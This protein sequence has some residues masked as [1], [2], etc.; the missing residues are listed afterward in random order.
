M[1]MRTGESP[2]VPPERRGRARR[3]HF[4]T[5]AN[6]FGIESGSQLRALHVLRALE[7]LTSVSLLLADTSERPPEDIA[8]ARAA[9]PD[10]RILMVDEPR[11]RSAFRYLRRNLTLDTH[12][13]YRVVCQDAPAVRRLFEPGDLIWAFGLKAVACL[14]LD[15]RAH[16]TFLDVD[17]IP[18]QLLA[19]ERPHLNGRLQ[20]LMYRAK[21]AQWRLRERR[22]TESYAGIGVCSEADRQYLGAHPSIHVIPNGFSP[23]AAEPVRRRGLPHRIGFIG[24]IRY[25]PNAQ[26]VNWFI[27]D[28][29][30]RVKAAVP[31]ARLRVVGNG[32]RKI[33]AS[34]PDVDLLGYVDD[35]TDEIAS[36]SMLVVPIRVGGGTRI[37]IAEAFSRKCPVVSTP[38]GAYGHEVVHGRELLLAETAADFADQCLH[39]IARPEEARQRADAAHAKFMREMTWDVTARR[40]D[41]A[42][43]AALLDE[44]ADG[45]RRALAPA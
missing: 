43:R 17:D 23:P 1:L 4:V 30:P 32:N 19:L 28:V 6:P 9:Y 29:W 41:A 24:N 3:L 34:G 25:E 2:P 10:V 22:L 21:V 31:D 42:V 11:D 37:K 26:G 15:G 45:S 40:V 18:S 7:R 12:R 20:R 33:T 16:R 27:R 39:I 44:P 38:L 5:F 35:P 8:A 36:W 14:G 13:S